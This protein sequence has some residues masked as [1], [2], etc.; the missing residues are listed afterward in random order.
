[1]KAGTEASRILNT[2]VTDYFYIQ[3]SIS[4][5]FFDGHPV[6]RG[7]ALRCNID[8]WDATAA[9]GYMVLTA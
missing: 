3:Y 8:F 5:L 6:H 2:E 9:S 4:L 7:S 1:M